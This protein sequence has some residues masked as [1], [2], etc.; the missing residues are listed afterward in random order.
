MRTIVD[1]G[2]LP[3]EALKRAQPFPITRILM[4]T[5]ALAGVS[6]EGLRDS[7][8]LVLIHCPMRSQEESESDSG[9]SLAD[10]VFSPGR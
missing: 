1:A 4:I 10:C 7:D 3:P 8:E 9:H 2:E 6:P 5:G